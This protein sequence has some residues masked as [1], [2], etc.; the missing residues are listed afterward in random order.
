MGCRKKHVP[1][2][3]MIKVNMNLPPIFHIMKVCVKATKRY[4][5]A[6]RIKSARAECTLIKGFLPSANAVS[7][8]EGTYFKGLHG[9]L[10]GSAYGSAAQSESATTPETI[11][12]K[13]MRSRINC[14]LPRMRKDI[15]VKA[16]DQISPKEKKIDK[17]KKVF[18]VLTKLRSDV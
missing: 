4:K 1:N 10:A 7:T 9:S 18:E 15:T 17:V 8:L 16:V 14:V 11:V 5:T 12:R 13:K 3:A 6:S 2:S